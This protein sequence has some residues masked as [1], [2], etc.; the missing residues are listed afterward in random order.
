MDVNELAKLMR[1][2]GFPIGVAIYLLV[3]FDRL[4]ITVIQNGSKEL[5]IMYQLRDHWLYNGR[6]ADSPPPGTNR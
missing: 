3:R 2:V 1:D 5:E 4:M 6:P